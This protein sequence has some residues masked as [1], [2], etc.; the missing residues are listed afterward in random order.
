MRDRIRIRQEIQRLEGVVENELILHSH[1]EGE[2][3]RD[4]IG[5]RTDLVLKNLYA[6][7]SS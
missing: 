7:M 3:K 4:G 5:G 6:G 2:R 1:S